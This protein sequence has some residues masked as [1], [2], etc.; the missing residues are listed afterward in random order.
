MAKLGFGVIENTLTFEEKGGV[1]QNCCNY[2]AAQKQQMKAAYKRT[3]QVE[4][5]KTDHWV[6]VGGVIYNGITKEEF[7]KVIEEALQ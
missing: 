6:R 1:Y 2:H 7:N 5:S 4:F 3:H